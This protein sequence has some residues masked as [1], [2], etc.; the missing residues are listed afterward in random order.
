MSTKRQQ[1]RVLRVTGWLWSGAQ[2][3]HEYPLDDS[4]RVTSLRD[5]KRIAGDFESLS[6]A[7]IITTDRLV[8]EQVATEALA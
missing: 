2:C 5:A 4:Q 8:V 6:S 7:E 3:D 1:F